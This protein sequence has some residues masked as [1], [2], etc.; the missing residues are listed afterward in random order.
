MGGPSTSG[1]TARS[2]RVWS[3]RRRRSRPSSTCYWPTTP[4][5]RRSNDVRLTAASPLPPRPLDL[6]H[7]VAQAL[8]VVRAKAPTGPRPRGWQQAWPGC[9]QPAPPATY[10][11]AP[12]RCHRECRGDGSHTGAGAPRGYGAS[13]TDGNPRPRSAE[14]KTWCTSR[15]R[16]SSAGPWRWSSTSSPTSAT[17]PGT[18]RRCASPRRSRRD[19]SA[20]ARGTG[21]RW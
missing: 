3:I 20:G 14:V 15:A 16:S 21:P 13:G 9:T 11:T 10:P 6:P 7:P 18:T 1:V 4:T 19:R 17:S 2:S 5:V 12:R 8:P